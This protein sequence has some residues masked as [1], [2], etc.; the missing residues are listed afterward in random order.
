MCGIVII[1]LIYNRQNLYLAL[2]CRVRSRDTMC[3]LWGTDK[4]LEFSWILNKTQEMDNVQ[5]CGSCINTSRPSS[6][7]YR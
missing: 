5:N 6:Q 3:F 1:T 2:A 4:P 7:T